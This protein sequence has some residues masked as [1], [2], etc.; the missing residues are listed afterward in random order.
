METPGTSGAGIGKLPARGRCT[1]SVLP[2]LDGSPTQVTHPWSENQNKSYDA[3]VC[4]TLRSSQCARIPRQRLDP[5]LQGRLDGT[6]DLGEMSA[7]IEPLLPSISR[8][9]VRH[10]RFRRNAISSA[11]TKR[12]MSCYVMIPTNCHLK[13][14]TRPNDWHTCSTKIHGF[15]ANVHLK[16]SL[17]FVIR[18][19][20][21]NSLN[22]PY[23]VCRQANLSVLLLRASPSRSNQKEELVIR[24]A[25]VEVDAE[26][27]AAKLLSQL[28]Q[29][30]PSRLL[31]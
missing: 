24:L 16:R 4:D 25:M 27:D 13:Y 6:D 30:P 29:T 10:R 3:H 5:P 21:K 11:I 28:C 2:R 18:N 9:S 19:A 31:N 15:P 22:N 7:G 23:L 20:G 26:V 17:Q 14:Q 12:P 8:A 1:D